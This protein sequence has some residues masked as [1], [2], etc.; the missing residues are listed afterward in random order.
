MGL[1]AAEVDRRHRWYGR[2]L[3]MCLLVLLCFTLPP[4]WRVV[5]FVG[6]GLLPLLLLLALG[7]PTGR[8]SFHGT[9]WQF[10]LLGI[11]TL[12]AGVVWAATP[13]GM[14]GTGLPVLVLWALFI[15]WSLVRLLRLLGQET[16][17]SR[18]V[19]M[20][21]TAG[22]LLLGLTAGLLFA[23]LETVQPDSFRD[24]RGVAGSMLSPSRH[25]APHS[26]S[27]VW[28]LDFV[29]INY[30]AFITLTSTGFGDIIPHTAQAQMATIVVA[31]LG[32]LYI[33]V[34]MGLL[35]SRLTVQESAEEPPAAT[36]AASLADGQ[37][38][39]LLLRLERL[40]R[41]LEQR[42]LP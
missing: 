39:A 35:I 34:V 13:L 42:P 27:A 7:Q 32:N 37:Q 2:L 18:R 21:A 30:F 31:V 11:A 25:L 3:V 22:Y 10:R 24:L 5:S 6:Y 41:H 36:A 38:Q 16:R 28:S 1:P 29:R 12:V 4:R 9:R 33:A 14:R 20:G 40:V 23:A 26:L 19:L 8:L 15:A 17:V